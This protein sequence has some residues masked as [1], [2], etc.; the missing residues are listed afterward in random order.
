VSRRLLLFEDSGWRALRPLTDVLPV[1]SLAFGA[2]TLGDRWRR[3]SGIELLGV[4]ARET[5][6]AKA[7]PPRAAAEDEIL[8]INAAALPGPWLDRLLGGP[9][10][11]IVRHQGRQVGARLPFRTLSPGLGGGAKL[12]AFLANLDV[13]G[14]RAEVR[15]IAYPWNLI[16]WN[17]EAIAEDLAGQAGMVQ[18]DVHPQAVILEPGRVVV[19]AGARV[20]PLAVLDARQGPIRIEARA[21]VAPQTVVVGPCVVGAGTQ[22]L[23]GFVGR[24]T[25]GPQCRVAGEVEESIWQGCANKRHHGFVGHSLIAEWV[26]LGALTTTSDLKNN[27]GSVRMWVDGREIDSGTSKIGAVIGAHVKTGIGTLLPTGASLGVGSNL[28]GGGR[29]APKHVPAFSWWD[30]ERLDEHRL[31]PFLATA[32]IAMGRRERML[33]QAEEAGLRRLFEATARERG[34]A[35]EPAAASG[36]A[37]RRTA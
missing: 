28:F 8:V 23:G 30:G 13:P 26:N 7:R 11:A 22:L 2:S 1:P 9:C 27:Y 17:A 29:F 6:D 36:P 20:D 3:R 32:R 19:E 33:G 12:E 21:R 31:E 14:E 5:A 10:P 35:A 34:S 15:F 37:S 24:S 4:E 16:E 18:G 25:F